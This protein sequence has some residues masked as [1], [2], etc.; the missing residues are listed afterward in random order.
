MKTLVLK[1][2]A[3]NPAIKGGLIRFTEN[4]IGNCQVEGE[5]LRHYTDQVYATVMAGID[6]LLCGY[7]DPM[8]EKD[9][10]LINI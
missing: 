6:A 4:H 8:K 5:C 7:D 1:V 10:Y 3:L 9:F 2:I